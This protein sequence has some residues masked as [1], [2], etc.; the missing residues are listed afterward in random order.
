VK[1][2]ENVPGERTA[3]SAAAQEFLADLHDHQSRD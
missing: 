3:E 2:C 1:F